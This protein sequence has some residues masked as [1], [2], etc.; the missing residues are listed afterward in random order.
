MAGAFHGPGEP[1]LSLN[2]GI[3]G[4]G[5][6]KNV[7][8]ENPEADMTELSEIIKRTTFKTT[9]AGEKI[10]R[11]LSKNLESEFGIVDIACAPSPAEDDS[12]AKVL[13][14]MGVEEAGAPG[15]T[16][17]VALLIDSIKKGGAMASGNVGGLSGTFIPVSEDMGMVDSV[18]KDALSL[19]KLEALTAVCSV[20]MDMVVVPGNTSA[21]KLSA[22]I[23]DELSIGLVNN[24]AESVRIIPVEGKKAGEYVEWGGLLGEAPAMEVNQYGSEDF[25]DRGG[26]M[27]SP[28]KSLRN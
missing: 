6:L 13:E 23:A 18:E 1:D 24:K 15:T 25:L 10:G 20:G 9:R 26:R 14:E 4:P 28:L 3:S 27:P 8:E 12:I 17:A 11:D 21:K 16:A 2:I 7:I 22:I 5:V 19:E